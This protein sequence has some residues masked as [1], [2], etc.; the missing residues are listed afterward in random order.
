MG[1]LVLAAARV[2]SAQGVDPSGAWRTW[3]TTHFRV[4][5]KVYLAAVAREAA[6][7]AERAYELLARELEPPRGPLDLVVADNTDISNGFATPF[8]TNRFTVYVT[9]PTQTASLVD[10][11]GWLRLVISHELTHIFHLDRAEGLWGGLQS[12][13]GRAPFLFPNGYQPQWVSEGLATYYESR[14]TNAGRVKGSFHRQ[15][16]GA[17]ALHDVWPGIGDVS[18]GSGRWP[19]GF[20]SYAF[21]GE[22]FALQAEQHGDTV[23]P[24]FVKRTS[25]Q[26]WPFL[27]S[28]PLRK[29]GGEPL[30]KAWRALESRFAEATPSAGDDGAL[31]PVVLERGL[32]SKPR[33]RISPNGRYI[34]YVRNVNHSVP[35]IVVRSLPD[36]EEIATRRVNTAT[37]IA[38][39]GERLLVTQLDYV[40]PV[41]IRSDLYRWRPGRRWERLTHGARVGHPFATP[42]G[43]PGAV[44]IA[45]RARRVLEWPVDFAHPEPF[46]APPATAWSRLE[47]SADGRWVAGARH[48]DGRWDIVVWPAGRPDEALAVTDDGALD[49]EV[50]WA[51]D[52]SRLL[53]ASE[54]AGLPQVYE[55]HMGDGR[56][57]RLTDE[58]TGAREPALTPDGRLIYVTMMEDGLALMMRRAVSSLP[59]HPVS[60]QA[61]PF[62]PAPE[63]EVEETGYAPWSAVL[64]RWWLPFGHAEDATGSFIGAVTGGVDPI[65]RLA[66]VL[67]ATLAT[68]SLRWEAILD[69]VYRRWKRFGLDLGLRQSWSS[70][71][72]RS[73][74]SG[75]IERFGERQRLADVGLTWWWRKWRK[76]LSVRFSGELEETKWVSH[77][78]GT[79]L[80]STRLVGGR[81]GFQ[82]G[83]FALPPLA[84]SPEDGVILRGAARRRWDLRGAGSAYELSGSIAGYLSLPLPGFAHW[85]LAGQLSGGVAGGAAAAASTFSLGGVVGDG[86]SL[87]GSLGSRSGRRLP[88]RGYEGQG[89]FTRVVTGVAE[90]RVPLLLIGRGLRH[91]PLGVERIFFAAFGEVGGA[92]LAGES[93]SLPYRDVGGEAVVDLLVGSAGLLRVRLGAA[94]PLTGGLRT[95]RH[96]VRY[97]VALGRSF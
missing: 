56:T 66:Y 55:Y 52:G 22:F 28:R 27:V 91:V 51:P 72:S 3:Q 92:W 73:L 93:L 75:D 94:V 25:R 81:L 9:P 12:V 63:V 35:K 78:R 74:P 43:A 39:L 40:S 33:P 6:H 38:W 62:E 13:L 48:A 20:R 79:T 69:V 54:R 57:L 45:E 84:I 30:G 59:P 15:I 88:L 53:F 83:S 18:I 77:L 31:P 2:G 17:A 24:Q 11:D 16:L 19:A 37:D 41:D 8:P 21:G 71:G 10:Y 34:A 26:V 47:V 85:V 67:A 90:L 97:Y 7:E 82:A 58:P 32:R 65:G 4:H 87:L 14:L 76:S 60:Q 80:S 46:P 23:V 36:L 64:P 61:G 68:D 86:P 96:N 49:E 1:V 50:S 44:D 29:A 95:G 42:S 5:A 89:G 70:A